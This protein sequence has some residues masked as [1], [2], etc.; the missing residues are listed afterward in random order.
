[1]ESYLN[2]LVLEGQRGTWA[3]RVKARMPRNGLLKLWERS[4]ITPAACSAEH[5]PILLLRNQ[6][7]SRISRQI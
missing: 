4:F 2:P 7:F 1:M 3:P 6:E 5:P